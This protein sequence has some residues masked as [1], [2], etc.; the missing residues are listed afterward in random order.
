M[1]RYTSAGDDAPAAGLAFR[2]DAPTVL[3]YATLVCFTFWLYAFGPALSL[4][5]AE[6]HF[7]YT[8]I[9]VHTA[10]WSG[11]SI[12]A[13]AVFPAA[14][15]RFSRATLLWSSAVAAAAGAALFVAGRGVE[16]T[17]A[18]AGVLGL[19]GTMLLTVVQAVLSDR[20]GARRERALGEAN[21]G[22]AACAVLAPL[23]LGALAAGPLG[24][25][26]AFALP[27]L[28]LLVLHLR[29]RRLVL[30]VPA[31]RRTPG[32]ARADGRLPRAA[33]L[34]TGLVAGSMAV[35]FCLV[36][37]G[38]EQLRAIGLSPAVAATAM[39]GHC[40]GLLIG[41]VG[42]VGA[43]RRPGRTAPLLYASLAV[44]GGGFALFWLTSSPP[45]AVAGLFVA[46]VGVANLY[47]LALALA[48]G[49]AA[50]REDEVNA[51]TQL[52]GGVVVVVAPY[53]L[54]LLADHLGLVAAFG[55]EP[56]LIVA[57][58]LLLIAGTRSGGV[59]P[60]ARG[61]TPAAAG[62]GRRDDPF[63]QS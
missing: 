18:G 48:L 13:G 35:E 40:L 62:E 17:L 63:P 41:R 25:R 33:R 26:A 2:R 46:G 52:L 22:A 28:G 43:T 54:G 5:R 11:G 9:G 24:W 12:V 53:S 45:L 38:A 44:T 49:A 31:A 14:A 51:R 10:I 6:L 4:L 19:G 34:F 3:S 32:P 42:G 21:I 16:G 36:Y 50:G 15:R 7:S 58:L 23:L 27:A 30:P 39:S 1:Y 56:A 47:P 57:C 61:L 20:H 60:R 55:V 29:Y 37:F 8:L 59:T